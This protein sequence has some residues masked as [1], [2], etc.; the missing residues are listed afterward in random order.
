MKLTF[1]IHN[2]ISGPRGGPP[3][4]PKPGGSPY[5]QTGPPPRGEPPPFGSPFKGGFIGGPWGEIL[6]PIPVFPWGGKIVFS[7][8]LKNFPPQQT[9]IRTAGKKTKK[10]GG[11]KRTPGG[12]GGGAPT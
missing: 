2:L 8:P 7:P 6:G 12:G 4:G 5:F 1:T 10:K 3:K 9:N 11:E